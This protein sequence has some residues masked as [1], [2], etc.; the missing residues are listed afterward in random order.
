MVM[1]ALVEFEWKHGGCGIKAIIKAENKCRCRSDP[2]LLRFLSHHR[3]H[4]TI[5]SKSHNPFALSSSLSSILFYQSLSCH[6][7]FVL[8]SE[9]PGHD[10]FMSH[11]LRSTAN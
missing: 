1:K 2:N 5:H 10:W 3:K 9:L 4:N 8:A 7:L 11:S 6:Q